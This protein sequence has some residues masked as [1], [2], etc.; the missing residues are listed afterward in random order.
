MSKTKNVWRQKFA[1]KPGGALR[2]EILSQ[3]GKKASIRL[4][5]KEIGKITDDD[6]E[7]RQGID[8]NLEDG[9]T[10]RVQLR[11]FII[12][13][14]LDRLNIFI[15]RNLVAV[16]LHPYPEHKLIEAYEHIS[17]TPFFNVTVLVPWVFLGFIS[18][19]LQLDILFWYKNSTL[20]FINVI[21]LLTGGIF[22]ASLGLLVKAKSKIALAFSIIL[23]GIDIILFLWNLY[24][25]SSTQININDGLAFMLVLVRV[26]FLIAMCPG[27]KAI[28][29]LKQI[30]RQK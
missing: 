29:I 5:D 15:N 20:V 17:G 22:F 6:S 25:W 23:Y 28:D 4:D 2:L 30:E 3:L 11:T 24:L 14:G 19:S 13:I 8:F 10:L 26:K 16:A 18:S 27:F 1:L 7:L 9:S 12:G 21:Y